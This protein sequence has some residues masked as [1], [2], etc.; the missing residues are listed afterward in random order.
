M[1][2]NE[3]ISINDVNIKVIDKL[4][5]GVHVYWRLNNETYMEGEQI[6]FQDTIYRIKTFFDQVG[7]TD[8]TYGDILYI[9]NRI[10]VKG[11]K[12]KMQKQDLLDLQ[13]F[14]K[15][16]KER[17]DRYILLKSEF[18]FVLGIAESKIVQ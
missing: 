5:F 11:L 1:P 13:K 8:Y 10:L 15:R 17:G 16:I 18:D 3:A 7:E 9:G 2:E 12:E 4:I 14:K 6:R